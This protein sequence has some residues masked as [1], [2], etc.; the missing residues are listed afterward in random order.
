MPPNDPGRLALPQLAERSWFMTMSTCQTASVVIDK[1]LLAFWAAVIPTQVMPS[2]SDSAL[3]R[4]RDAVKAEQVCHTVG[5]ARAADGF[6]PLSC[7]VGGGAG[8]YPQG[9]GAGMT[10]VEVL[11]AA[12]L[13]AFVI[14]ST[15]TTV[16]YSLSTLRMAR[17]STRL[18]EYMNSYIEELR[19]RPYADI[20]AFA[21][22]A[23]PVNLTTAIT[24]ESM[25]AALPE[26]VT[27]SGLFTTLTASAPM[28]MGMI[29]LELTMTWTESSGLTRTKK[30]YTTFSEN[31]LSD[32]Y[33]VGTGF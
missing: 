25:A 4:S 20:Q 15:L 10:L 22:L 9:R 13:L 18:H 11:I 3:R 16:S 24:T 7:N 30:T 27:A 12:T 31:G 28:Q 17:N 19:V 14:M 23:Q 21:A 1:V 33:Y 8:N 32:Q 26:N 2:H 6:T 5:C 29:S